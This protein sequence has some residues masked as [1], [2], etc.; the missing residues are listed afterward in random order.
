MVQIIDGVLCL[1]SSFTADGTQE[2]GSGTKTTRGAARSAAAEAALEHL[3]LF[4]WH[5]ADQPP[6][7]LPLSVKCAAPREVLHHRFS[8]LHAVM[9]PPLLW[10][11]PDRFTW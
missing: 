6:R 2:V 9:Q 11:R 5:V 10:T 8:A 4:Q 7:T 3:Q 1:S